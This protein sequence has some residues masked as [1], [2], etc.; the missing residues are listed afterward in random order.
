MPQIYPDLKNIVCPKAYKSPLG[1]AKYKARA[2]D[3]FRYHVS[4]GS[5]DWILH[6]DEESTC[7]AETIRRGMEFVR[8]TP[9]HFGQGIITY[10]GVGYCESTHHSIQTNLC[11]HLT[12]MFRHSGHNWLFTV[13]DGLRVGDDV[14]RFHLQNTIVKRP[15]FGV[16]GSFLF[17]NGE[18]EN[19]CTWDFGSLAEDFEFS[20]DAWRRGFTCGRYHGIVREQSP[21]TVRDFLKQRRR[22]YMGIRDIKGMYGLPHLA[23]N[24]WT[25][26]VFTLFVTR[27]HAWSIVFSYDQ[28]FNPLFTV[29][30]LPFLAFDSSL[31]PFW[32]A[33][34]AGF[35]FMTFITLYLYVPTSEESMMTIH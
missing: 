11:F 24:L 16:H 14:A 21:T 12:R 27:E 6:M 17:T 19:E 18:M 2:L 33:L 26:G 15:I 28:N 7:D 5:H 22:W 13:A 25:V 3:Y 9:H 23:T 4:L 32:I 31:T 8:Y 34:L 35:C 1:K 30:N 29:L 20:Q 10:N